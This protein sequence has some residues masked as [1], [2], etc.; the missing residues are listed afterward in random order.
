MD[1]K[2]D[3][4]QPAASVLFRE[5]A[6]SGAD[7][8]PPPPAGPATP[9]RSLLDHLVASPETAR[10]AAPA[11]GAALE[12]FLAEP[13]VLPALCLWFGWHGRAQ[14]IP[15][16]EE[17]ARRLNRDIGRIDALLSRQVN[18]ILHHPA[19]Q[20]L[21]ASWRGLR[22]LV[23]KVPVD[24]TVKVRV[25]NL[26]WSEL[27]LDQNR[28]LEFD[29][30]QLFRK[31]YEEEFGHPGG[32]PFGVLLGDYEIHNH[33]SPEHPYDDLEALAKISGV[34]AAAFAPFVTGVHPSFFGL[35]SFTDLERPI[36]LSRV[37]EQVDYIRWRALR[38]TEDAR[39]VGLTMPRVLMRLPHGEA[40]TRAAGF[41]FR[42]D[43][44]APDRRSYL[45]GSAIYA[46]AGVLVRC[47]AATSWLAEIRGVRQG[48]NERG[49]RVCLDD[50]GLV[51]ALPAHSFSTDTSGVAIKCSTDVI[52]ADSREN[53]L[54][55]LGFI[56]LCHAFDTGF[57]VFY[58]NQSIQKPARY[59]DPRATANARL[60]SM[61]QYML[62][63]SRFA[64]YIKVM[65]RDW[66]G[67]M[68]TPEECEHRLF[69]WLQNYVTANDSA[70]SEVKSRY[71]LRE[72]DVEVR[73][74][75]GMPGSYQ[76]IIRLR[77]HF[78][79]DQMFTTVNFT[80]ELAPGRP[81]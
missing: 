4:N 57:S 62:C 14:F 74:R 64:H 73:E 46:F 20:K 40:C 25:L 16:R 34:A 54:G 8:V 75:P 38:Q 47:Y 61:L 24:G 56:P 28:A 32:E 23:D 1:P 72:A 2:P 12:Q 13:A 6:L 39:F 31:V 78:Q 52:I 76:S 44:E 18:A 80:T 68:A 19:F 51:T 30:S 55:D 22:Y 70:G 3:A 50:G 59:D 77:P 43:V 35:D 69:Q 81:E 11:S 60:S 9:A 10:A 27:V 45:W 5:V 49:V 26:P 65:A 53:E 66:V 37:F 63:A 33:P 48:T 17:I 58:G 67:S 21:E 79:L 36:D 7:G 15:T 29:Q 42:E 71:P 41:E